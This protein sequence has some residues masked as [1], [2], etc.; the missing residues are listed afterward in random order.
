MPNTP[1]DTAT[2][3]TVAMPSARYMALGSSREGFLRSLAVKVTM[4]NPRNAKNVRATLDRMSL[5]G[6]YPE[7]A[8]RWGCMLTMVTTAKKSRIPTTTKTMADC[9]RATTF[10][11]TM[12]TSVMT[13]MT[14]TANPL[15]QAALP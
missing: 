12:F 8:S 4:P 14:M 13:T 7:G 15:T 3:T 10:A 5:A 1:I 6:G 11:P 2:Y 9:T